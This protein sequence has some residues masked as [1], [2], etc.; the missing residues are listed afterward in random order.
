MIRRLYFNKKYDLTII[1]IL[2]DEINE[3]DFLNI[4]ENIS[5]ENSENLFEFKP[6]CIIQYDNNGDLISST[7]LLKRIKDDIIF[8]TCKTTFN[9]SGL[10]ILNLF[11]YK[12]IGIN[13]GNIKN[14]KESLG[15]FLKKPINEINKYNKLKTFKEIINGPGEI[16]NQ[17][18]SINIKMNENIESPELS[19]NNFNEIKTI[20]KKLNVLGNNGNQNNINKTEVNWPYMEFNYSIIK[21]KYPE[22]NPYIFIYFEDF[23]EKKSKDFFKNG[24]LTK[25]KTELN[26]LLGNDFSIVVNNIVFG[27][28]LTKIY[29]FYKK[30]QNYGKK[31]L[32]SIQ[33]F[34]TQ[35]KEEFKI[36]VFLLSLGTR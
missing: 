26:E 27:S 11:N 22:L 19:M 17:N 4:D 16:E 1:E 25:I 9:S 18:S 30:V 36:I 28:I 23:D 35:R 31:E 7:G 10:P 33:N 21:N 15:I 14:E 29:V 24:G 32:N 2:P 34:L 13:I 8:H 12:V 3:Y 5:K 6:V 20:K